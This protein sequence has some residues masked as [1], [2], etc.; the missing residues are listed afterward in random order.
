M[1]KINVVCL[2]FVGFSAACGAD[3]LRSR[4]IVSLTDEQIAQTKNKT[5]NISDFAGLPL[6]EL[7]GMKHVRQKSEQIVA[8]GRFGSGQYF[9]YDLTEDDLLYIPDGATGQLA[10]DWSGQLSA[11]CSK[12]KGLLR[13]A[14][15]NAGNNINQA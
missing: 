5:S 3:P 6:T 7:Y 10:N 2:L 14:P 1:N 4:E 11:S 13:D 12:T 8:C 9:A 15:I